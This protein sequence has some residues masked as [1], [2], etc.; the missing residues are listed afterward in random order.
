[1]F[2]KTL[3]RTLLG[4]KCEYLII[5]SGSAVKKQGVVITARVHPGETVGSWMMQGEINL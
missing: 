3:C 2:R 5:T 1:M 4:N